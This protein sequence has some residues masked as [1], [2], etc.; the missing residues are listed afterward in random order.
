MQ[1]I[2]ACLSFDIFQIQIPV[3]SHRSNHCGKSYASLQA[4]QIHAIGGGNDTVGEQIDA[5]GG[6]IHAK[7]MRL[8][9]LAMTFDV[10]IL[11]DRD[12]SNATEGTSIYA[13]WPYHACTSTLGKHPRASWPWSSTRAPQSWQ[14]GLAHGSLVKI[15]CGSLVGLYTRVTKLKGVVNTTWRCGQKFSLLG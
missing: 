11:A 5:I 12:V 7:Q 10:H 13:R 3:A 6:Q 15:G 9:I 4:G 8:W 1:V 2:C 14:L